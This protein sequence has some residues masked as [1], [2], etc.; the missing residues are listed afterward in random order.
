MATFFQDQKLPSFIV[1]DIAFDVP[2]MNQIANNAHNLADVLI[3][4][5]EFN[6]F[7]DI[8]KVKFVSQD[9][10]DFFQQIPPD[11][12]PKLI[13]NQ[14]DASFNP[15]FLIFFYSIVVLTKVCIY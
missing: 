5:T 9:L 15:Q 6:S 4:T 14:I 2:I 11:Y 12:D 8:I 7:E 13:H 10:M 1:K 3:S